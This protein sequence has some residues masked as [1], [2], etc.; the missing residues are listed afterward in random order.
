MTGYTD[1]YCKEQLD[2]LLNKLVKNK[3]I[4][5]VLLRIDK[6]GKLIYSGAVGTVSFKSVQEVTPKSY[7]RSASV[8]K[9]FTAV[10]V[11]R[12]YE[13]EILL[14]DDSIGKYLPTSLLDRLFSFKGEGYGTSVTI[15]QLLSHTSGLANIDNDQA[16]NDWLIASSAKEKDPEE[17]LEFAARIGPKFAP[18]EGQLYT[19]AGYI[20]LGLIIEAATG[21]E[22]HKVVRKEVLDPLSLR[23]TFE[24]ANELPTGLKPIHSYAGGYNMNKIHPSMEFAD[25]GFVTTIEDLSRF[26]ISLA[27]GSPFIDPRTLSLMF[28]SYGKEG[29]GL[30]PFMGESNDGYQYFYH[31]GHWGVLLYVVPEK[32]LSVAFTVNQSE[33]NYSKFLDQILEIVW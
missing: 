31:P 32:E 3:E 20:L 21:E 24:H 7:F 26:G 9:L 27:T 29:I 28:D 19:S 4:P 8:G 6:S 5:S 22:Y 25:G 33:I 10:T 11:L 23:H 13:K 2:S 15:R 1:D 17:L 16:K 14:L 12:L 30:G 18:G